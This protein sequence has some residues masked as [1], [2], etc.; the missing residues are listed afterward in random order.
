[1]PDNGPV[2]VGGILNTESDANAPQSPPPGWAQRLPTVRTEVG[3]T[4]LLDRLGE[5]SK[6]GRLPGF[7]RTAGADA[8]EW[9]FEVAA[10]GTPFD[11]VLVGRVRSEDGVSVVRLSVRTPRLFPGLFALSLVVSVWPGVVLVDHLI[12]GD[13]GWW[14][15]WMWYLPLTI[16]PIPWAWRWAMQRTDA[17]T[18]GSCHDMTGRIA[19]EIA[20]HFGCGGAIGRELNGAVSS[21]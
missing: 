7:V 4:E 21:K 13:W 10:F 15:T 19:K 20:G 2:I 8:G 1:M 12:P 14:P 3:V 11:R 6:R 18:H 9:G 5:A 16:L 17:T